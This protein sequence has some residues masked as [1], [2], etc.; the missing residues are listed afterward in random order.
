MGKYIWL[1]CKKKKRKKKK[2]EMVPYFTAL[3][4]S[5]LCSKDT[6]SF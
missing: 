6:G 3:L 2:K 1:C 4:L 5:F